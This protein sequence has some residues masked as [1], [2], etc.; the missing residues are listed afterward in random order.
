M[1]P[2][3]AVAC[4]GSF[5]PS[6]VVD[7]SVPDISK[8][9]VAPIVIDPQSPDEQ[10]KTSVISPEAPIPVKIVIIPFPSSVREPFETLILRTSFTSGDP[11]DSLMFIGEY[12][13]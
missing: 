6:V 1:P 4:C 13:A 12:A 11:S 8:K 9:S 7:E 3:H 10:L 2:A 5:N